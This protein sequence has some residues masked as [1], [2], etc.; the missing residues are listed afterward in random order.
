MV[1]QLRT[2]ILKALKESAG[3]VSG[4]ALSRHLGTS[5]V[6]IWKH[7]RRLRQDGYAIESS[8]LGY[9]LNSSPNLLLPYE[10][11]G[12]EQKIHH[13]SEVSSTMDIARELAR[14]GAAAGTV[15]IAE[16]QSRGRG[17]LERKWYSPQGGIYLSIILRPQVTPAYAPRIN[18]M[19]A[20]AIARTIREL[21][22]LKAELKWP[23]DVLIE[24]KK[25]CGI[26]AEMDAEMDMVN[27]VSV[28]IGLNANAVVSGHEENAVSL[29]EKVGREI[30]RKEFCNSAL[31]AIEEIQIMLT[32]A[33]LLDEWRD[34]SS[35]LNREVR[36]TAPGEVIEGQAVDIDDH[37]ALMVKTGDGVLR[38]IFAGDC[39]H[40]R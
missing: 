40:L 1:N 35:T 29:R 2:D 17:R 23:N 18:L 39:I 27:Y 24:G 5:R 26:L 13:S 22:G 21:F 8:S 14:N 34:L 12:M 10:F 19:V 6:A 32:G 3:H 25:V 30:S 20:V 11:P 36:I 37:G 31:R 38:H 4:E 15:V 16:S 9:R 28:G 33:D 7:I